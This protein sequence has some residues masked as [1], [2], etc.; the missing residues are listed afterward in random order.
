MASRARNAWT[1]EGTIKANGEKGE[2]T[3]EVQEG[4]TTGRQAYRG[5]F[6]S[7]T[8]DQQAMHACCVCPRLAVAMR[9]TG[10]LAGWRHPISPNEQLN[11]D[12]WKR[13]AF[14]DIIKKKIAWLVGRP[15]VHARDW[16][17]LTTYS[18]MIEIKAHWQVLISENITYE[19]NISS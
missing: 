15:G 3:W 12:K 17:W 9:G 10:E 6:A 5:V 11:I 13:I 16:L 1:D 4:T 14:R 18:R 8:R 19:K 7:T 2:E